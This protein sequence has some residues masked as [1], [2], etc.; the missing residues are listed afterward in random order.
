[1]SMMTL[2]ITAFHPPVRSKAVVLVIVEISMNSL[3]GNLA[4]SYENFKLILSNQNCTVSNMPN[5]YF[6]MLN[7][8][9]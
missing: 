8:N 6:E 1:M 7:T 2:V 9:N 3:K 4:S 5:M